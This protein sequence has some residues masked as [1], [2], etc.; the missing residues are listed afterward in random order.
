MTFVLTGSNRKCHLSDVPTFADTSVF[1][2]NIS[3]ILK[4]K[5]KEEEEEEEEEENEEEEKKKKKK[6]KKKKWWSEHYR[7][8]I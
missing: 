4:E 7:L 8:T 1:S 3:V 2:A 5:K 6:K